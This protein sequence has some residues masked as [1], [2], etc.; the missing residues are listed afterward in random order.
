[1]PHPQP[2]GQA[3]R[4]AFG[5]TQRQSPAARLRRRGR[6]IGLRQAPR[7]RLFSPTP[8]SHMPAKPEKSSQNKQPAT[9]STGRPAISRCLER[10]A[11]ATAPTN[12]VHL[13]PSRALCKTPAP[14]FST[15][16]PN[17]KGQ[18]QTGSAICEPPIPPSR[19]ASINNRRRQSRRQNMPPAQAG[20][21]YD[22]KRP[23]LQA[24]L[25]RTGTYTDSPRCGVSLA[26]ASRGFPP[27]H[28]GE[29]N[30]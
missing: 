13:V 20:G 3:K 24:L 17:R 18:H 9:R 10:T 26:V 2:K 11:R 8:T 27:Q 6:V 12:P 30:G 16:L 28:T 7:Q 22:G 25:R 4:A 15:R 19:P 21:A 14:D 23:P 1:M 29:A 5:E